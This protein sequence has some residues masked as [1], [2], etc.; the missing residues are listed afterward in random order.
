MSNLNFIENEENHKKMK[1]N[2]N[3]DSKEKSHKINNPPKEEFK[4]NK[5][6]LVLEN[7]QK[8]LFDKIR[9]DN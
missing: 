8:M 1:K 6:D 2:E 7:M 4:E 9:N 5:Q 3:K